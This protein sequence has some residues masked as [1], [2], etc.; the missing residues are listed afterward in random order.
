[1]SFSRNKQ[2]EVYIPVTEAALPLFYAN[3]PRSHSLGL[4]DNIYC[5]LTDHCCAETLQVAAV[6]QIVENHLD[7]HGR[8]LY[9]SALR[10]DRTGKMQTEEMRLLHDVIVEMPMN[11]YGYAQLQEVLR[12]HNMQMVMMHSCGGD[13]IP[14]GRDSYLA[15]WDKVKVEQLT[16]TWLD[17][18]TTTEPAAQ[19]SEVIAKTSMTIPD[20]E[21][22]R[23][24]FALSKT[25][26][27]LLR[28]EAEAKHVA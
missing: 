25:I 8:M 15:W 12:P 19:R 13:I 2:V 1:M 16:R 10:R 9:L 23:K 7:G 11:S 24:I 5:A 3:F 27:E 21:V 17:W 28:I 14:A 6:L 22:V 18:S 26:A 20:F 4:V